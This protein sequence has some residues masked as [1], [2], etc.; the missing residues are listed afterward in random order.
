MIEI[1][2]YHCQK[3]IEGEPEEDILK[4]FAVFADTSIRYPKME[5]EWEKKPW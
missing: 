4:R 3:I 5:T 1:G 2:K